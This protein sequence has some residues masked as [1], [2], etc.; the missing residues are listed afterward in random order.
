MADQKGNGFVGEVLRDPSLPLSLAAGGPL[1]KGAIG[2]GL[3]GA[4]A[5]AAAGAVEGLGTGLVHQLDNS[6]NGRET[7]A[8]DVALNTAIGGAIPYAPKLISGGSKLLNSV[9]G[10]AASGLSGA[11]EK[12]L[13]KFGYGLGQGAKELKAA[14]G[15]QDA[16]A[17]SLHLQIA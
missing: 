8:K 7:S 1:V 3:K 5:L 10:R 12:A 17:T 14:A 16:I 4:K 11:S 6:V 15:Q 13:R 2:L 9:A